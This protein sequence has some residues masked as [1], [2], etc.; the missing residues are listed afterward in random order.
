MAGN[1]KDCD[2]NLQGSATSAPI[3]AE[4]TDMWNLLPVRAAVRGLDIQPL[5][6]S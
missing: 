1:F 6:K 4:V 2:D 5:R 3:V